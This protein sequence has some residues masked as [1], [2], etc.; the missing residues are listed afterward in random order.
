[1][2]DYGHD[3]LSIGDGHILKSLQLFIILHDGIPVFL[4]CLSS[5]AAADIRWILVSQWRGWGVEGWVHRVISTSVTFT[6]NKTRLNK[7]MSHKNMVD[8]KHFGLLYYLL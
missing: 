4:D 7:F 2:V 1:M 6:P 8:R 5:R 3:R